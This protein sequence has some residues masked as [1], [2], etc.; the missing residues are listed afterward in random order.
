MRMLL[1]IF[2]IDQI[3]YLLGAD[4]E[5]ITHLIYIAHRKFFWIMHHHR[6]AIHFLSQIYGNDRLLYVLEHIRKGH[7][8]TLR[9]HGL[10]KVI[11]RISIRHSQR[12]RFFKLFNALLTTYILCVTKNHLSCHL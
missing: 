10:D 9:H 6:E 8:L 11:A 7:Y 5:Q 3:K 1:Q 2:M 4:L 12:K